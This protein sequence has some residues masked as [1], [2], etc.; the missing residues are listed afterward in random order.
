MQQNHF[1]NDNKDIYTCN[2]VER[3]RLR[4]FKF[5]DLENAL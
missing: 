4:S 2:G 3:K 5:S 1:N